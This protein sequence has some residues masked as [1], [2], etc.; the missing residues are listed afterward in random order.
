MMRELRPP[1]RTNEILTYLLDNLGLLNQE[2]TNDTVTDASGTSGSSV[3][4]LDGLLALGDLGVLS[5]AECWDSGEGNVAV[6][7]LGRGGKLL[8]L[9]V[10][11]LSS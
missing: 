1:T 9:Q 3:G 11:E 5:G 10:T 6:S 7:A 4:A 8:D 2:R